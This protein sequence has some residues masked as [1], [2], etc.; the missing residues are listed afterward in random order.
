MQN[1]TEF[2]STWKEVNRFMRDNV[3]VVVSQ[4]DHRRPRYSYELLFLFQG[5]DLRH[6]MVFWQ[7]QGK[8][9]IF[10]LGSVIAAL[11]EEA[12]DWIAEKIQEDENL[13]LEVKERREREQIA[14]DKPKTI[15][16]TH[17]KKTA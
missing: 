9:E 15:G 6:H 1:G 12:E 11:I 8:V 13:I 4:S 10:R 7:G 17:Q 2:R 14:R 3:A 16:G 5:R